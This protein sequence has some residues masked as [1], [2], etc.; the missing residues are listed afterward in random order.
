[1]KG[2]VFIMI[3]RNDL[4]LI[5]A[6]IILC[7]GFLAYMYFM[8][9]EGSKVEVTVDGNVY[10]T[11]DLTEDTTFTVELED[12]TWNTFEIKDGYVNMLDASCP[13]KLCVKHKDIHYNH[14]TIVCLP[15]KVVLEVVGGDES[16]VD[17]IAN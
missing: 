6:V 15:N 8:K 13:D 4:I 1:M 17:M 7:L 3:K 9:E 14:E 5:G 10:D 11:F 12:G 2:L 16:E